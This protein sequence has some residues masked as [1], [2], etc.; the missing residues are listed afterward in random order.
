MN[1]IRE[2]VRLYNRVTLQ[3]QQLR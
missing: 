2:V 3:I 1:Y